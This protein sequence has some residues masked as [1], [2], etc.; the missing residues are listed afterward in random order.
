MEDEKGSEASPRPSQPTPFSI[1]DILS[2]RTSCV[3]PTR[4]DVQKIQEHAVPMSTRSRQHRDHE[5]MENEQIDGNY[6]NDQIVHYPRLP[7]PE[8]GMAHELD[9]LRRNLV[10]ANLSNFGG[11]PHLSQ[12]TFKHHLETLGNLTAY[13][14]V[15]ESMETSHR[16]QDEALDMSKNKYLGK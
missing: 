12:G 4:C 16:Q 8:L 11:I 1:A 5:R 7:S 6:E 14:P 10:Q 13:Q 9:M 15:K 2:R 3:D